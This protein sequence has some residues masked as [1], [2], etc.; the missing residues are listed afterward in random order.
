M[1]D[2]EASPDPAAACGTDTA[3]HHGTNQSKGVVL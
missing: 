2:S 3:A 1:D